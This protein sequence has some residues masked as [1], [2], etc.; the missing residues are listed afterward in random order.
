RW[1]LART[2]LTKLCMAGGV[3][4]NCVMNAFIR[5]HGP[6]DDVWLQPASGDAGT[7]LGAALWT[8]YRLRDAAA[9][10]AGEPHAARRWQ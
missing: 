4:L 2:G 9:R 10:A 7:A 6:F 8:D 3:A 5:D 1:L